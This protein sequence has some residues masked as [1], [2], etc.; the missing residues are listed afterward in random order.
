MKRPTNVVR[1]IERRLQQTWAQTVAGEAAEAAWP[2]RFSLS[3]ASSSAIEADFTTVV[4]LTAD[5]RAWA[6]GFDVELVDRTR[7]IGAVS[8]SIPSHLSVPSIDE[9]AHICGGEWPE[10]LRRGRNRLGALRKR[11]PDL[12]E[13][14]GF[15]KA[16]DRFDDVDFELLL[17]AGAWF[18]TNSAAGLTPRQVPLEGF[19]AKWLNTRQHLVAELAGKPSLELA[20]NHPPRIHFSYLDP[21]HL[22]RGG[23][24]HDSASVGDRFAPA[25]APQVV[26]I[27]ENKDTAVNFPD[28]PGAISVE[29]VGRGG[30]TFA[31]FDWLVDAP[32]VIYW[33]DMDADGLEILH[34]FRDAGVP[35]RSIFMDSESFTRWERFGTHVDKNGQQ[36]KPRDPRPGLR[37]SEEERALYLDL[38]HASWTKVRRIEQERIPLELAREA[39]LKAAG[40]E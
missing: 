34:G 28:V 35:A 7:R 9:A 24:K 32:V 21:E 33:G 3:S 11:F 25:Y 30:A 20:R 16:T 2:H 5:W 1:E 4:N 26:I 19:H 18:S 39:V 12:T 13:R 14:S 23:R 31:A 36:L 17:R 29:G 40:E 27:S 22:A 37:L 38:V 15:L 10:R 8:H 6:R